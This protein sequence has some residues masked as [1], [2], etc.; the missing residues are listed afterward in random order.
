MFFY[1]TFAFVDTVGYV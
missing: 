1:L